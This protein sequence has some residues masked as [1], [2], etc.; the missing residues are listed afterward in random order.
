[1]LDLNVDVGGGDF[2][3]D[4]LLICGRCKSDETLLGPKPLTTPKQPTAA[5]R[6]LHESTHLPYADWCPYCVAGKKPN[7]PHRRV[8]SYYSLPMLCADYAFFGDAGDLITYIVVYIRPFTS[9]LWS[10]LRVLRLSL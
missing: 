1:M 7:S 8:K 3:R 9:P 4:D 2:A 5:E 6:A 10:M